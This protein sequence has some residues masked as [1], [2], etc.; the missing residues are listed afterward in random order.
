MGQKVNPYGIRLGINKFWNSIWYANKKEYSKNLN[1]DFKIRNFLNKNLEQLFISKI[2]IARNI[3]N[4]IINIYTSKPNNIIIN[5]NYNIKILCKK[6]KKFTN[7]SATIN[8][9]EVK[10]PE[11]NAKLIANNIKFQLEKRII[12]RRIIKTTI[13]NAIKNGAQGIKI[14]LNGRIGGVE[15]ARTEW[16][17]EGRVPLHTLRANIDYN[18]STANTTYGIIGI[19]IWVFKGEILNNKNFIKQKIFKLLDYNIK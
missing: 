18:T 14:E 1:D 5:K 3:K 8:M 2:T 10:I 15:I 16:N 4:T 6:I 13:Q 11:I 19:K 9:F 12:F 17:R 7:I